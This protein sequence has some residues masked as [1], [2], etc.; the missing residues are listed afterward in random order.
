MIGVAVGVGRVVGL[1]NVNDLDRVVGAGGRGRRG[2]PRRRSSLGG[3]LHLAEL[4]VGPE[5]HDKVDATDG[6]HIK[7]R[8]RGGGGGGRGVE[9]KEEEEEEVKRK[10]KEEEET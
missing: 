6:L 2:G 7:R 3:A 9:G 1:G 8:R 4:A 5:Q 10:E